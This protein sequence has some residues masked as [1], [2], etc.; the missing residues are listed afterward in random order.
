MNDVKEKIYD[1]LAQFGSKARSEI[2][3]SDDLVGD[4][5][6]DSLDIIEAWMMLEESLEIELPVESTNGF[7]TVEDVFR[8]VNEIRNS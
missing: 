8:T 4:L 1:A 6:M 2:A 3:M 7:K 5:D